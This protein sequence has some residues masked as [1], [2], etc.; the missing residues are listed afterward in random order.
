MTILRSCCFWQSLRSGAYA[1]IIYTLVCNFFLLLSLYNC[2]TFFKKYFFVVFVLLFLQK[3]RMNGRKTKRIKCTRV[4]FSITSTLCSFIFFL[5]NIICA[6]NLVKWF[7]SQW[8]DDGVE[9]FSFFFSNLFLS[10][11]YAFVAS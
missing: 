5:S 9:K 7:T 8:P 2:G 6:L 10:K 1:S 11:C 3:P 4:M